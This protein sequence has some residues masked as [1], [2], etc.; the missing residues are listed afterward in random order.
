M[1]GST[2]TSHSN[3]FFSLFMVDAEFLFQFVS[4]EIKPVFIDKTICAGIVWWVDVY[5]FHLA[6]IALHQMLQCIQI[7][8]TDINVL[9]ISVL[10]L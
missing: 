9:T 8:T 1:T 5:T 4:R 7:V 10:W 3:D 2:T 6:G